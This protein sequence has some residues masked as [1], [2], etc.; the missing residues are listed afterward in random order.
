MRVEGKHMNISQVAKLAGVSPATVSRYLNDGYVSAE[1]KAAIKK[2]IEETGYS[3]L[4]SAQSL[5]QRK[6]KVIGVIVPKISSESISRI[7]DGI[8]A[9]LR[10]S[11]YHIFL[12]NTNNSVGAELDYLEL[13]QHNFVDGV[14]LI[15]TEL[16][17][18]H[19][20]FMKHYRKPVVVL[21][22]YTDLVSCVYHDDEGGAQAAVSH[23]LDQGCQRIGFLGV[24]AADEAAG[25]AR[26]IGYRRALESHGIQEDPD[27]FVEVDFSITD[28]YRGAQDLLN[29]GKPFDGL[30]CATD[31][32][33]IGAM[34]CLRFNGFTIPGDVRVAGVGD[35]MVSKAIIPSL[36][37][38]HYYYKTSGIEA[39]GIMLDVL[40]RG[41]VVNK[42][43]RLGYE[44]CERE[45]TY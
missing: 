13:F 29:A 19:K 32:I 24:F 40:E 21:G 10:D 12:G 30:F 26:H 45:S 2:V 28:G 8:S 31:N 7:V 22:Q 14:I 18:K 34:N 16:T 3:P 39:A 38:I 27:L 33:A 6:N 23:L 44:L 36:T 4:A 11:G 9:G 41:Q 20:R 1:K 35:S 37:S 5:R 15:A 25:T 17:P 43:L 42:Q